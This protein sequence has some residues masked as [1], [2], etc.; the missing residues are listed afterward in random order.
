MPLLPPLVGER[1]QALQ[2]FFPFC[3]ELGSRAYVRTHIAEQYG[4]QSTAY[5]QEAVSW[6][7]L[8]DEDTEIKE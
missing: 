8:A 1:G 5:W 3:L 6:H 4:W 2:H 7:I